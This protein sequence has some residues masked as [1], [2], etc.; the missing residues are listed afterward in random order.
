MQTEKEMHMY[1]ASHLQSR[2]S[3][4]ENELAIAGIRGK[5]YITFLLTGRIAAGG[6]GRGWLIN[7]YLRKAEHYLHFSP[8]IKITI[9]LTEL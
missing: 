5:N 4:A 7:I 3:Y 8:E 1:C 9:E 6:V 2:P